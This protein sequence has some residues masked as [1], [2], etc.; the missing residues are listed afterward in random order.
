MEG[1]CVAVRTG[2]ECRRGAGVG[3]KE[4]PCG[5]GNCCVGDGG[6]GCSVGG[7]RNGGRA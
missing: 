6:R 1:G 7:C 5:G 4:V 3:G 2:F